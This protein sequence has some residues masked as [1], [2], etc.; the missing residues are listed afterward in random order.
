MTFFY[1]YH[2]LRTFLRVWQ[3]GKS[4]KANYTGIIYLW[5]TFL[6]KN[7]KNFSPLP[8][9]QKKLFSPVFIQFLSVYCLHIY[10]MFNIN[11]ISIYTERKYKYIMDPLLFGPKFGGYWFFDT[12]MHI[13]H[14]YYW[15]LLGVLFWWFGDWYFVCLFIGYLW[16]DFLCFSALLKILGVHFGSG[17]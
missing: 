12:K 3:S 5:V 17:N 9:S 13:I 1:N 6:C 4:K 16:T 7:F 2:A 10:R 15:L 14:I 11:Y 8:N